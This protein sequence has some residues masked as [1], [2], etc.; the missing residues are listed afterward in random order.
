MIKSIHIV[1]LVILSNPG[2]SQ[3][4]SFSPKPGDKYF[5]SVGYGV[6]TAHW[7]SSFK[8]T[9]FYDKD[10]SII[11]TGD[12]K[13]K[14]NSTT[15][16]YD[17]NVSIPIKHVRV[18][19]GISFEYHYL[20]EIKVYASN[21][22]EYLLFNEGLRFDKMYLHLEVPFKY[23]S[24]K[25]YSISWNA[26]LGWY[27][28]TYVRRINFVGETPF[29]MSLLGTTGFTVDYKLYPDVYVFLMPNFE[30]KYYNNSK[31]DADVDIHHNIF[32][33]NII[34]GIRVDLSKFNNS[35]SR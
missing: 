22:S 19:L 10:G 28:Y 15:K 8:S 1:L 32:T 3:S 25:D 12:L 33:T 31:A 30:F 9:D 17:A 26:R 11:H 27:G 34:G 29:A 21:F 4:G 13:L 7:V 16:H 18:G 35:S 24:T 2:F 14:A 23:N 6:G 20:N 5:V